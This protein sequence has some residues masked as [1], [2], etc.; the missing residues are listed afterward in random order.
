ME[1]Y[2]NEEKIRSDLESHIKNAIHILPIWNEISMLSNEKQIELL[3]KVFENIDT[4]E[5]IHN[6][7][8]GAIY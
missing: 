7:S 2:I 8:T 6:L 4:Y 1:K 3:D 5:I